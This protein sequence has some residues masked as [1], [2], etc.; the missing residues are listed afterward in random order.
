MLKDTVSDR[1]LRFEVQV[2][3]QLCVIC[4]V[5]GR[6]QKDQSVSAITPKDLTHPHLIRIGYFFILMSLCQLDLREAGTK[7]NLNRKY[8]A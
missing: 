2:Q 6:L 4:D 1:S 3:D 7:L 5:T 8:I